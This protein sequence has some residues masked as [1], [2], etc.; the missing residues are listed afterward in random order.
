MLPLYPRLA[1]AHTLKAADGKSFEGCAGLCRES[2]VGWNSKIL[3]TGN[4]LYRQPAR[5]WI[6][7]FLFMKK[8][9]LSLQNPKVGDELLK[10]IRG[11]KNR[12]KRRA[13]KH[14]QQKHSLKKTSQAGAKYQIWLLEHLLSFVHGHS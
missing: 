5:L 8:L 10:A 3:P 2:P 1:E 6:F 9:N 12:S 11:E 7:T 14:L 4:C 13:K